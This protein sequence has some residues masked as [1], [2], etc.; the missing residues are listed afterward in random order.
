MSFKG[1][2]LILSVLS[3]TSGQDVPTSPCPGVF[4]YSNDRYQWFA[5]ISIP[6]KYHESTMQLNVTLSVDIKLPSSYVGRIELLGARSELVKKILSG[7]DIQYKVH[8]PLPNVLPVV[9][10]IRFNGRNV[11]VGYK[12]PTP[13]TIIQLQHQLRT[14]NLQQNSQSNMPTMTAPNYESILGQPEDSTPYNKQTSNDF[15]V[16]IN[17][18]NDSLIYYAQGGELITKS[19]KNGYRPTHKNSTPK[20]VSERPNQDTFAKLPYSSKRPTLNG[21]AHKMFK[22]TANKNE[23]QGICGK[24][25]S[26]ISNGLVVNGETTKK[27]EWPWLAVLYSKKVTG[28]NFLCSGSLIS[29]IFLVTAAHCVIEKGNREIKKEE[30]IIKLGVFNLQDWEDE[31]TKTKNVLD[32][33]LHPSYDGGI[34]FKGDIALLKFSPVQF[35]DNIIPICLWSGD[36]SLSLVIGALGTVVGW[37]RDENGLLV[38]P[39]PRLT[40]LPIVSTEVCRG[41]KVEFF[42]ITSDTTLCAG[43]KDGS[44]P[45]NGDS[46]GGLYLFDNGK[47]RWVLRGIVSNSLIDPNSY[48]VCN[49]REYIVFTDSAKY[50]KWILSNI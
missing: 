32:V 42:S 36:D 3:Q 6:N 2:I 18:T 44:G 38:T 12:T 46:G 37:G 9:R 5:L 48:N 10:Y 19:S 22:Y 4:S 34:G 45:C 43:S 21:N 15:N 41:S 31:E 24:T 14:G 33:I 35:T 17:P 7:S 50:L 23:I 28:F 29:N 20:S 39:E 49:L 30:F 25:H 26:M 40:K 47:S 27:G 13:V 16:N 1:L 8:F 11:C